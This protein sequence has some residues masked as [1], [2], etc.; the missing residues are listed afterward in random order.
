MK[1]VEGKKVGGMMG[2]KSTTILPSFTL[3]EK[4]LPQMK[5]WKVGEKYDLCVEVEMTKSMKGDE[6]PMYGQEPDKSVKG[7]FNIVSVGVDEE[8]EDYQ[9]EYA[10]RMSKS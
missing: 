5:D 8:E 7:T 6:Y 10:K 3:T 4:D 2:G 1:K 9:T